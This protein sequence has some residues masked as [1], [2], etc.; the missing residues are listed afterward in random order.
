ML[1]KFF[2][3]CD[4]LLRHIC[5]TNLAQISDMH[6]RVMM[7][8]AVAGFQIQMIPSQWYV[9]DQKSKDAVATTL[10]VSQEA[11]QNFSGAILISNLTTILTTVTHVLYYAAKKKMKY[12]EV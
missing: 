5:A 10:F 1:R 9:D 4:F 6:F 11:T 2:I 3:F 12:G 7:I 8:S